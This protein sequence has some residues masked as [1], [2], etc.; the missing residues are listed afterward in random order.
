MQLLAVLSFL[1]GDKG[2]ASWGGGYFCLLP[3]LSPLKKGN[4]DGAEDSEGPPSP[5]NGSLGQTISEDKAAE[6]APRED[7]PWEIPS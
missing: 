7:L 4:S 3:P 1:S 5:G 6:V 2:V